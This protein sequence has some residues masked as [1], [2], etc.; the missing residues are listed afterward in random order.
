MIFYVS[1]PFQRMK[2]HPCE[3]WNG[4]DVEKEAEEY[5]WSHRMLQKIQKLHEWTFIR[6]S[7]YDV[8]ALIMFDQ[9]EL[10]IPAGAEPI[11]TGTIP[12]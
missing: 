4:T 9:Y 11:I 5:A 3:L 8:H 10:F 7:I 12:W 1:L 6:N 2:Q